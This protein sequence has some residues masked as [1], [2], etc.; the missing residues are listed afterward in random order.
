MQLPKPDESTF[1]LAPAGTHVA[2]CFKFVDR[3]TRKVEYMG[4]VKSRHEVTLSWELVDELMS[5][6]RPFLVSKTYTWSTHEKSTLRRDLEAWRGRAF[7]DGDF[8]GPKAFDTKALLGVPCMLTITHETKGDKTFARVVAIGKMTKGIAAK[9]LVN[10]CTY[11]ALVQDK[12]DAVAFASLS[13][14]LREMIAESPEY[15]ALT[16]STSSDDGAVDDYNVGHDP[17]DDIPF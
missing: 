8:V 9:P 15:K 13:S 2:R 10:P 4:G 16:G 17:V 11:V 6:G 14:R 3:G 12:F 7:D 1:E 5:D